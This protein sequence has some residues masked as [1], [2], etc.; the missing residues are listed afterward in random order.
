[1]KKIVI[2]GATGM[3][4]SLLARRLHAGGH[5]LIL[6][7]R[8][9]AKISQSFAFNIEALT[10]DELRHVNPQEIGIVVNLA[11]AGVSD[12]KWTPAYK[13]TMR[14]SRL[15]TTQQCV[16]LCKNDPEIRL[17]NASAVS[18]YGFYD[19]DHEAFTENDTGKRSGTNY[20]QELIDAWEALA[21]EAETEG[22]SVTLLR[23][24]IVLDRSG[25]GLP[26]MA[27]PY[28][29]FMGGLVGTGEQIM[30][31]IS[32]QDAVSAIEFIIEHPYLTGPVNLVSTGACSQKQFA[33]ALGKALGKPSG[34]H[35]PGFMIKATMGQMGKKLVLTGQRVTPEKL[36]HAGFA[37]QDTNIGDFLKR[38]YER[39][40]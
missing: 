13:Q 23:T 18:A 28:T 29:F 27:K 34:F 10:W 17:I 19:H 5:T 39:S 38:I 24:G 36:L 14:D 31:W 7:G 32:L 2:C 22:R 12:Q 9:I 35:M 20:L 33:K 3:V 21:L 8:D 40:I 25:G 37:F 30:S 11:G 26:A 6:V 1:M 16:K 15:N 4:G